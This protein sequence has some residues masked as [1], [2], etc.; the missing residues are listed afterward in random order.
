MVMAVGVVEMID[1]KA[2]GVVYSRDP[3][4][5]GKQGIIING[6]WGLGKYV[7]DGI[8]KPHSYVVSR[9]IPMPILEKNQPVQPFM[10]VCGLEGGRNRCQGAGLYKTNVVSDR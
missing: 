2:S 3:T 7:V 9:D 10:L 6:V 5:E 4:D 1:A 8:V